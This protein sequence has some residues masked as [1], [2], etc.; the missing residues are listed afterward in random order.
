MI[1]NKNFS[2]INTLVEGLVSQKRDASKEQNKILLKKNS[3]MDFESISGSVKTL[4]NKSCSD[5]WNLVRKLQYVMGHKENFRRSL[6]QIIYLHLPSTIF[7]FLPASHRHFQSFV[8]YMHYYS[9]A[10]DILLNTRKN[11]GILLYIS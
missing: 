2:S 3:K 8:Q 11:P 6:H 5:L 10:H 4:R 9:S 7:S 1:Q